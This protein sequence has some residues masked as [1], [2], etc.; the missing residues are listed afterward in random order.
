MLFL[1]NFLMGPL[2]FLIIGF[3]LGFYYCGNRN[4]ID[5]K[6]KEEA[7]DRIEKVFDS[8]KEKAVD[9]LS[10]TPSPNPSPSPSTDP[11][12]NSDTIEASEIN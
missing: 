9:S 5:E 2:I 3:G 10:S 12:G 11:L 6:I 1:F 8:A 4:R 7:K